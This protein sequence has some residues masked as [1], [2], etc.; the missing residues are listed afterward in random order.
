MRDS[1]HIPAYCHRT[2]TVAAALG[3]LALIVAGNVGG[4]AAAGDFASGLDS[5]NAAG[6]LGPTRDEDSAAPP[7]DLNREIEE[8]DIVKEI[9]GVF[10]LSNPYKGL[11][12]IDATDMTT[13]KLVGGLALAGRGVELFV[14]DGLAFVI[15]SSDFNNCAA[16]AV[17]TNTDD[18]HTVLNPDFDGSR[19]SVVNVSDPSNPTL[20]SKFDLTGFATSSR[21]VDDVIYIVGDVPVDYSDPGFGRDPNIYY[22]Y[23][24]P[25]SFDVFVTSLNIADPADVKLV[26]TDNFPG[27]SLDVHV[28][29]SAIYA[30]GPDPEVYDTTLI[31]YIDITDATGV[32]S[33]RDQFRV[34]GTLLNR[35]FVDE[36]EDYL[37]VVTQNS[38]TFVSE[39]KL[40]VY[41][42]SNP[43]DITR[44]AE[45]SIVQGEQ[46]QAVRFDGVRGY[47][48]TFEIVDPLF[49]IDLRD[50]L[51][52]AV[53]GALKV[54]G[55]STYLY[56]F[57]DR[58]VGVG[59]DDTDG[60]RPA[61]ALYDV[62]DPANPS[63]LS[64]VIVGNPGD[65]VSSE[66]TIDEKAIKIIPE[67]GLILM[68]FS[69]YSP[70]SIP[71][72]EPVFVDAAGA[73]AIDIA[74][75]P[76][77]SFDALQIIS[78]DGKTLAAR[79]VVEHPG[80][81]R[82]AG[83]REGAIWV[84]SDLSFQTV[85]VTN[86]DEPQSLATLT[87]IS[88]Q[89]LLDAGLTNCI[90]TAGTYGRDI[91]FGIDD[92][93]YGDFYGLNGLFDLLYSCPA[94]SVA[95]AGAAFAGMWSTRRMRRPR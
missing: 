72:A 62:A 35:F 33:L 76:S 57:G 46:L 34:P 63:E 38:R 22:D 48:V 80:L 65:Y 55:Y 44:A 43:D 50:P 93:Y 25:A 41:D 49:V 39:V 68:P 67:A 30:V 45:L 64:R 52:P 29:Q 60:F 21:R 9:D 16:R 37:R 1:R 10:Y 31:Q 32:F 75:Y 86:P 84:M 24:Y 47:V 89:E 90:Q 14:R 92:V 95:L 23:Y 83:L 8:A 82:R 20:V 69:G 13:P 73:P 61:V 19:L 66:A 88:E 4:C 40:Y 51:Q 74:P 56:P 77:L 2:C 94:A 5:G 58:L 91:F 87:L 71:I 3:V 28:S 36:S 12:I 17:G 78:T 7:A 79:G 70:Q 54:P 11:R 26:Q 6:E 15:T 81:V 59:F 18:I 27:T 42:V 85:D 53:T